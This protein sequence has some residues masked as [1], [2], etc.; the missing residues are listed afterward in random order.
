MSD[1]QFSIPF[2]GDA[3]TILQKA[4]SAVESQGG[5]FNGDIT[6]GTFNVSVFGNT[7][8]GSYS[9]SG[10]NLNITIDEKPFLVPCN[11]IENYLSGKLS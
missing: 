2:S 4:K 6:I 1:C 11:A 10:N 3:E 5:D 9:V 8:A 7:I